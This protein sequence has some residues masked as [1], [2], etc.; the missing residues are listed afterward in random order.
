[1]Y[2]KETHP[3]YTSRAFLCLRVAGITVYT[4][5]CIS[6]NAFVF[7]AA[8]CVFVAPKNLLAFA[9]GKGIGKPARLGLPYWPHR[10]YS[11]QMCHIGSKSV[12]YGWKLTTKFYF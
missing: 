8:S 10:E 1:M 12:L 5:I 9:G 11:V 7:Y 4:T 6:V 2:K 3:G